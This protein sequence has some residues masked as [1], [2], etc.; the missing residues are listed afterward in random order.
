MRVREIEMML[1]MRRNIFLS[2]IFLFRASKVEV[3]S[4]YRRQTATL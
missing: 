1:G 2:R 4:S 3:R